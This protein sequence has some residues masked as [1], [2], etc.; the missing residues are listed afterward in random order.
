[1][2]MSNL[3]ENQ[4]R[5]MATLL[6]TCMDVS[7]GS[8]WWIRENIW[9][10][11]VPHYRYNSSRICHPGLSLRQEPLQ[12]M[13]DVVPLLHGSSGPSGPLV[14]YGLS[15]SKGPEHPTSFGR[16]LAPVPLEVFAHRAP[17]A[18]PG[19][20]SGPWHQRGCATRNR[21]KPSLEAG[22]KA[23]LAEWMEAKGLA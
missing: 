12:G 9:V 13:G 1:M 4:R 5:K 7:F 10:E 11:K 16:L 18:D 21:H 14:V 3:E 17:N 2:V 15:W 22:E 19:E 8:L 20:V 6:Q 23:I